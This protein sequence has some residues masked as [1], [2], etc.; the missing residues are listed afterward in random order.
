MP[1]ESSKSQRSRG[2]RLYFPG[3]GEFRSAAER[4]RQRGRGPHGGGFRG[5]R[6]H[7]GRKR[8]R[9][10]EGAMNRRPQRDVLAADRP[11]EVSIKLPITL[12]D[13][14]PLLGIKQAMIMKTLM[15]E[16]I[17]ISIN[18]HLSTEMLEHI[19][20]RYEVKTHTEEP[21]GIESTLEEIENQEDPA[22]SLTP[23]A[24]VVT[25]LG[26]VDHGKTSLLDKIRETRVVQGEAG[27]ITQH[28]SAYRVDYE[29]KHVV[30]IDTPGH[31]AFTEMRARG[32]NVTD[33][34]VLVVAA[35]DGV[36]PQTEEA[37]QHARAANV[38][39]VVALNKVDKANANVMR[40]KD[41]LAKLGLSPP[42]WGGKTEMVE[43]S[44]L[45]SAGIDDLLEILSLETEI[46]NLRANP[47]KH[48]VGTLLDAKATTGRGIVA[49]VLV[50]NGTL[51]TGDHMVCGSA[52]GRV[53]SLQSTSGISL[54]SAAPSTPVEITGLDELPEAGDRFY[55]L[56]SSAKVKGIAEERKLKKRE[57]QRAERAQRSHVTLENLLTHLAKKKSKELHLVLKADVRGTL[58]ALCKELHEL[59]TDEVGVKILLAGVGEI[60]ESDVT[61]A[62]ASDAVI[63]GFH[64]VPN[65]RAR[66]LAK[67]KRVEIRLYQVIYQV[68]D[69]MKLS[70]EGLLEPELY[71]ENQSSV[72]IR[73]LFRSTRLGNIAGCF[74]RSGIIRREDRVR[75]IREGTVTYEGN[76][77][78]LKRFKDDVKEVKEGFECGLRI[79]GYNDI[80]VGDFVESYKVLK[81]SRTL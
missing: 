34:V 25:L 38:P 77:S 67:E 76:L 57:A 46:L 3:E 36:M 5:G 9:R 42:D 1:A 33:V 74:V 64:V 19:G 44:A 41:Q 14:S 43:V 79:E 16:Q 56:E 72:E 17:L 60:S 63:I 81:K 80:K 73:E 11:S 4:S 30:F 7:G 28:L 39:I 24:P 54:R 62:D 37:I 65:D 18:S 70:L 47:D 71:E 2:K 26:H 53:R 55:A 58:D 50:Q 21:A 69:E 20:E 13:L 31:K 32:A 15:D 8:F 52:W 49:T 22:E 23:R 29:T 6:P 35:D 61:L 68:L 78:S 51:K 66:S 48:A 27:G 45:T 59:R 12:K 75:L 40:A 10:S